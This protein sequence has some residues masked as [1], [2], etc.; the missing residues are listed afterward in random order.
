MSIVTEPLVICDGSLVF[1][2]TCSV[3]HDPVFGRM[4]NKDGWMA[5]LLNTYLV[6]PGNRLLCKSQI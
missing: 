3:G 5:A 2:G 6:L 1:L 4:I